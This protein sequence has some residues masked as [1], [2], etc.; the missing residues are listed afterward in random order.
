MLQAYEGRIPTLLLLLPTVGAEGSGASVGGQGAGSLPAE[1]IYDYGG[2]SPYKSSLLALP[3]VQAKL[4]YLAD[5][6][7]WSR[8][9]GWH[10]PSYHAAEPAIKSRLTE[11]TNQAGFGWCKA[12][13]VQGQRIIGEGAMYL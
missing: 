4:R 10:L 6:L 1:S 3:A 2:P 12:K 9:F 8:R 13:R 5:Q 11:A 7:E